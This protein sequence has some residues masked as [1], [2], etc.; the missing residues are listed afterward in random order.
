M[1]FFMGDVWKEKVVDVLVCMAEYFVFKKFNEGDFW[2]MGEYLGVME[3][4]VKVCIWELENICLYCDVFFN[5][6][7]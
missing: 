4:E 1:K 5:E 7:L 6:Y 3:V 2:C